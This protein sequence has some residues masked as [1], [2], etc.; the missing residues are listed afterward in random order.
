VTIFILTILLLAVDFYYLKNIAGRR[1]V[2][3]RWWNEVDTSTGDSTWVFESSPG[4]G[5]GGNKT[6]SRF[7]W[8]GLYV[9]PALWIGLAVM[10]VLRLS[11]VWLSVIGMSILLIKTGMGWAG[12][13]GE[14]ERKNLVGEPFRERLR[15]MRQRLRILRRSLDGCVVETHC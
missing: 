11:F 8:L 13:A 3:L 7:F 14:V 4:R 2:G 15:N 5:D 12:F 9:Q 1:L 10:A 6:D